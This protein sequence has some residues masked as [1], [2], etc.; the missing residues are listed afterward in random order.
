M[1]ITN[2]R[3]LENTP[4]KAAV[5]AKAV[6]RAAE[7]LDIPKSALAEILGISP[8]SVS[9]LSE[10]PEILV[11]QRKVY[12]LAALFVRMFRSLDSIT[13]ADDASSRSWMKS[14]NTVLRGRP[15]DVIQTAAGLVEAIWYVDSRRAKI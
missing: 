2:A 5:L 6:L 11:R 3:T 8:S 7:L 15:I 14:E 12:E 1:S 9:R 10:D 13:G 4:E